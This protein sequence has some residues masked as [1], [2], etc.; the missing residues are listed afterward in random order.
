VYRVLS[1]LGLSGWR[2]A[3]G[4]GVRLEHIP[5]RGLGEFTQRLM[6]LYTSYAHIDDWTLSCLLYNTLLIIPTYSTIN[7][8][9]SIP[10]DVVLPF[11]WIS[12]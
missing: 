1:N 4:K 3:T 5:T 9:Q 7:S 8:H 12:R 10:L 6:F 2:E 11:Q